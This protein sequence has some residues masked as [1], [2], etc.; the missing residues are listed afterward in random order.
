M[1]SKRSPRKRSASARI[2]APPTERSTTAFGP[3]GAYGFGRSVEFENNEGSI[4]N[5]N[6][7][8]AVKN[9]IA[10]GKNWQRPIKGRACCQDEDFFVLNER[11]RQGDTVRVMARP[12][13]HEQK[14]RIRIFQHRVVSTGTLITQCSFY[15]LGPSFPCEQSFQEHPPP[16]ADGSTD[17]VVETVSDINPPQAVAFTR[18]DGG[19]EPYFVAIAPAIGSA[20]GDYELSVTIE[21]KAPAPY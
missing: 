7:F 19:S 16:R 12:L 11:V 2:G 3:F 18:T 9:V 1:R 13:N 21:R 14:F 10:V 8:A 6:G 17:P 15:R 5:L 20:G 4:F